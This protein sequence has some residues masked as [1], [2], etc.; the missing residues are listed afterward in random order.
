M[1]ALVATVQPGINGP[2]GCNTAFLRDDALLVVTFISDDPNYED[3]GDPQ[4]WFD[5]VVEAKHG[6]EKS[7]AMVGFTPAFP[8]CMVDDGTTQGAHWAEFVAKFTFNIH[9][10][11]CAGDYA[12]VFAQAV[13]VVDES[14]EQ[15]VPPPR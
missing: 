6:D 4:S 12:D 7:I 10:P 15:F 14:C 9:A 2:D 8:E 3:A 5:A 1:D 11:V 13:S